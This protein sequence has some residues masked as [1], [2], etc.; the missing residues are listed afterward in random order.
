MFFICFINHD[1]YKEILKTKTN[2]TI[3]GYSAP[4][5]RIIDAL[6]NVIVDNKGIKNIYY[7]KI[8]GI[9]REEELKIAYDLA[10]IINTKEA[11]MEELKKYWLIMNNF[12]KN[13]I[14]NEEYEKY[15]K[16][17]LTNSDISKLKMER[18]PLDELESFSDDEKKIAHIYALMNDGYSY[19]KKLISKNASEEEC[20]RVSEA[21]ISGLTVEMAWERVYLYE[22]TMRSILGSIG[23]IP[24]ELKHEYLDKGYELSDIVG[25]SFL[26]KEYEEYLKGQKAI[27]QVNKDNTLTLIKEAEK[28]NDLFLSIDI[29]IQKTIEQS[30]QD[31]ILLGKKSPNTQ[32]YNESYALVGNPLT[33]EILAMSGQ[34]LNDD[35]TFSDISSNLIT[36]S[37]TIGSTVKGATIGVGYKYD[38]ID[39][40][41][42]I[43]DGC[44]KL[45]FVPQK[46]SFKRLGRI[47]DIKALAYS[48][49]YY[50]FLIAIKLTGNT[51]HN[52]M[53]L[54]ATDEHFKK[55]R[56]M[57]KSFG[58]GSLT[59]IDLPGE[60]TGIEGK[61]VADDL[62]L[63]LAIGQYDTYTPVEILQYIN[64]VSTGKRMKL[65]IVQKIVNN[66]DETILENKPKILND[67]DV[68]NDDLERIRTGMNKV[69]LEGT[70]RGFVSSELNPV[71]KTGTSET[72]YEGHKTNSNAF[73]GYF[74]KDNPKYSLVVI[75]PNVHNKEGRNGVKYYASRKITQ[76][77]TDFLK[78]YDNN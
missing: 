26:E 71:G 61:T 28:G 37:F 14:T 35:K 24:Q 45:Y 49:N 73:A 67:V 22:N 46:C 75:T 27:Y 51:Y 58:L 3:N 59:E 64:S 52:N 19:Q 68:S 55:Y 8:K 65:N 53:K 41:K 38:L 42:Y 39:R 48:S 72:F 66:K 32:Y 7:N 10:N 11:T 62:L 40:D 21:N 30:L 77:I 6:G 4:R 13:L 57:L 15:E 29:N 16:R 43:T 50:Q 23:P 9:S 56:D 69:L 33:G 74:P 12:G 36:S 47:N 31:K 34:R 2:I 25:L 20:A 44:V 63:N 17:K 76:E 18:I 5:G 70:G 78:D 60:Q 54:N 1:N